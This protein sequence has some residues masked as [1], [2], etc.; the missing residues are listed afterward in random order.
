MAN[1]NYI[2]E[3]EINIDIDNNNDERTNGRV[4]DQDIIPTSPEEF[5]QDAENDYDEQSDDSVDDQ[6]IILIKPV[7]GVI[8]ANEEIA[9][10][11]IQ[12]WSRSELCPLIKT[13]REKD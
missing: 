4:E 13:R 1:N 12:K 11:S 5:H 2:S 6:D 9:R 7:I 10:K 3:E 8:Y